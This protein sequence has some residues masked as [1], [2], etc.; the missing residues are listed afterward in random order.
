[1]GFEPLFLLVQPC[2]LRCGLRLYGVG[3]ATQ[4]VAHMVEIQQIAALAAKVTLRMMLSAIT[5]P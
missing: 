3:S 4:V 1:M 2:L 5:I